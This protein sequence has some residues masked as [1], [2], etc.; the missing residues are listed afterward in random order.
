MQDGAATRA[1]AAAVAEELSR[2]R[3]DAAGAAL[4]LARLLPRGAQQRLLAELEVQQQQQ[5]ALAGAPAPGAA[6]AA[7]GGLNLLQLPGQGQGQREGLPSPWYQAWLASAQPGGADAPA[8]TGLGAGA[9]RGIYPGAV[10]TL[11]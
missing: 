11:R 9:G 7:G 10:V 3:L 8:E 1:V 5:Q 4:V 2:G 6:G